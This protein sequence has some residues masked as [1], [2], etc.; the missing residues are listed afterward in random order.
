[1]PEVMKADF[2]EWL[3]RAGSIL[4]RAFCRLSGESGRFRR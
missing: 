3:L 1:M 4:S 2:A